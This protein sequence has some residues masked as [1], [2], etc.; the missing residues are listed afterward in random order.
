MRRLVFAAAAVAVMLTPATAWDSAKFKWLT[1]IVHPTHSYMAEYAVGRAQKN[2]PEVGEYGRIIIEGANS[3]LH[4]L[5]VEGE[6]YGLDLDRKRQEHRGSNAGSDDVAGWWDDAVAAYEA[7]DKE[8]AWYIAGVILHMVQDMGVPAHANG[9]YHQGTVSEFDNF[10]AMGLQKWDPNFDD[11]DRK[12]PGY[13]DPSQYYR[14][15]QKWTA[16]D[17]PDYQDTD[18]FSKTW[19]TASDEEEELVRNRQ[20]RTAVLSFWTL[21]RDCQGLWA[22][23]DLDFIRRRGSLRRHQPDAGADQNQRDEIFPLKD[24]LAKEQPDSV[25]P[26]SGMPQLNIATMPTGLCFS[27]RL[28]SAKA[29][30]ESA[31]R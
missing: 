16:A 18:T 9:V 3:E 29:T 15:S 21:A 2:Y 7:G 1:K 30:A 10:E 13:A 5:P 31:A 14:F 22:L 4:E 28:H 11:I 8:Q 27:S 25:T 6:A 19:L 24:A 17:A 23:D 20:G 12:D 26:N